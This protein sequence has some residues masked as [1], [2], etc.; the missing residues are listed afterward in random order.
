MAIDGEYVTELL[1]VK[2]SYLYHR[3]N[4]EL[5]F[6]EQFNFA[7]LGEYFRDFAAFA[8]NRGGYLIFGVQDSPRIPI[9]L[10]ET[11]LDQFNRLDPERISGFLLEMFS[12]DIR[13][14][15]K[16]IKHDGKFFGVFR[17]YEGS[18]KPIIA[19][20]N[21]GRDQI[22]KNGEIY[23][24]YGGRT[25]KILYAELEN[26]IIKRV[27]ENNHQW[28]SLMSKIGKAGPQ[29]AAILDTE[30][31]L[32]EKDDSRILVLDE[33]LAEKLK[34]IKEGHFSEKEGAATLRLVGDVVPIDKVEVVKKIKENLTRTYPLSAMQ[35]AAAVQE[36][37]STVPRH[38]IWHVI[39]ENDMKNNLDYS[40]Y[41]FRNKSQE[42]DY[43]R[44]G[45][46]PAATPS[47]YNYKAVDFIVKILKDEGEI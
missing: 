5:E 37:I 14:E 21:E 33:N 35:L 1:K 30:K 45:Y 3:E 11:S 6:K 18:T 29:N 27:E 7:G 12:S 2:G 46:I 39:S 47:I 20:K 22:I 42:D 44:S 31:A 13:W 41:N 43:K 26:I 38:K 23:Y 36:K 24:R 9:G 34:F 4:Q 16:F 17:I 8:N 28:L 15:Q 25:Q 32:I 19:K 10:T 40:A